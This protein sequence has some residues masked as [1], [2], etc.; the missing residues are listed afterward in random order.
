MYD[1][2]YVPK[3]DS[4][5]ASKKGEHE[6][7]RASRMI[8][9]QF[10]IACTQLNSGISAIFGPQDPL[11]GSHIQS[12]CDALDIPHV[13]ARLDLETELKEFSIN[14]YPSATLIGQALRDLIVYLNWT[15]IA[16]IYEDDISLIKLQQ[17]VRPP[18]SKQ[19]QFIFRKGNVHTFRDILLD[20]RSRGVY[21]LII[22]TRP[23]SLPRILSAVSI[24]L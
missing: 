7:A 14:L 11:L 9:S 17:L 19:V 6:W 10:P 12:L 3:E 2:Q 13:E 21:S 5:H 15:K 24:G 22:D 1:I 16:V 23:E 8:N 18:L 20:V 4:F